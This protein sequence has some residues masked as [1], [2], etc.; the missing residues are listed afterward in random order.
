MI[1]LENFLAKGENVGDQHFLLFPQCFQRAS[2]SGSL[3]VI[4]LP[5]DPKF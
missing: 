5:H 3:N 4:S 2:W 1:D